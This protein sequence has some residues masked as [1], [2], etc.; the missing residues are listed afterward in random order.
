LANLLQTN[1]ISSETFSGGNEHGL[2]AGIVYDD[3]NDE[4]TPTKGMWSEVLFRWVPDLFGNEFHYTSLTATHRQYFE[5]TDELAFAYRIAGRKMTDGAPFFTVPQQD[6]SFERAK[7]LGGKNT[8]RGVA[9][10]RINGKNNMYGNLEFRYR[11][12]KIFDDGYVALNTFYDFGR[13]FDP[14]PKTPVE[15]KGNKNDIMHQGIGVG[16]RLAFN[17]NFIGAADLGKALNPDIDGSG[18]KLYVGLDWLF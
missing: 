9:Y 18:L 12:R 7:G 1:Q 15:D 4:S 16:F 3:R 6:G 5:I 2:L 8:I 14:E 10:Q 13:S 11:V 17:A